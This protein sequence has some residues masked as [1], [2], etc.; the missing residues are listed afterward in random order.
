MSRWINVDSPTPISRV[1]GRLT[2]VISHSRRDQNTI[3]LD[4]VLLRQEDVPTPIVFRPL[5]VPSDWCGD[6][7][8]PYFREIGYL[9]SRNRL[10]VCLEQWVNPLFRYRWTP[11]AHLREVDEVDV[12][13]ESA[14]TA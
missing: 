14:P 10:H 11:R 9:G 6:P 2:V 13:A 5:M 7:R 8:S 4:S 12:G 1:G 3:E